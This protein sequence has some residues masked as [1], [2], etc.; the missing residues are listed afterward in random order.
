MSFKEYVYS[1]LI[2]SNNENFNTH[3]SSA[4]KVMEYQPIHYV[5]SVNEAQRKTLERQYDIVI[6]N[7][8]LL[9][10]FGIKFAIDLSI[11]NTSIVLIF[12]RNELYDA[13]YEKVY[14]YGI[15]TIRKPTMNQ[16]IIQ[17][18]DWLKATRERLRK[19]ENKS[20]SL[21]EKMEEIKLV[22]RAKWTLINALQMSEKE[23]HRYIEKQAMDR[24][25]TKKEIA[26]IIIKTY[27]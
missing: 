19:M 2:V 1:V 3:F 16:T 10:D 5:N 18:L 14:E 23:A 22:N 20:L 15:F 17:S 9:D 26:E 27:K 21:K 24:S 13:I 11:N 12:V 4:L 6:I 25:I 8:P 7:T